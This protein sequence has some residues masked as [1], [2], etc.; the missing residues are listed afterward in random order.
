MKTDIEDIE[1]KKIEEEQKKESKKENIGQKKESKKEKKVTKAYGREQTS[2][3]KNFIGKEVVITLRNG[4][5]L[6]GKLE[7]VVQYELLITIAYTPTIVMKHAI[8]CITL[9]G[10]Q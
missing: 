2:I 8:D 9:A 6:K 5:N 3:I 7:T 10:E 1:Q 4:N